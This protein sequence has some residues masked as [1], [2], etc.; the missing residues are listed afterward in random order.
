MNK[1][2][3]IK[4]LA[5]VVV[6]FPLLLF[7]QSEVVVLEGGTLIDGPGKAPVNDAVVATFQCSRGLKI[8]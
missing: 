3:I 5:F 1:L 6:L 8:T 7:A 4:V 2:W